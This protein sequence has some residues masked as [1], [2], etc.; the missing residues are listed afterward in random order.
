MSS[1]TELHA[2]LEPFPGYRLQQ[3]IGRGGFACV[4]EVEGPDGYPLALKFIR[5][6]DRLAAAE[7]IRSIHAFASWSIST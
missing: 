5:A 4:W 3:L 2:G 1:F 7:E 6:S